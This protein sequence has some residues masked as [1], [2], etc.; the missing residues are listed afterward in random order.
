MSSFISDAK[1]STWQ[2]RQICFDLSRN[3][4]QLRKG[5][6]LIDSIN[7]VE[8]T[9]GNNGERGSLEITNLRILWASHKSRAN[10]SIGF[11]CVSSLRI[12][13]A[14]SKLRGHTQALF[15]MT[16]YGTSTFE[17]IF[18][19]LVKASPRLFTTIQAVFRSYETS[20]LYRDL[21]LRG[22]IIREKELVLLPQE[23]I[24]TRVS[25]VWNLSSD[26]GNL[27][28]LLITNVRIVWH[29]TLAENFNVS[30]PFIQLH[31]ACIRKSKFG[32]ALVL[33]TSAG[34][35]GYVLGFQIEPSEKLE[36]VFQELE[37]LHSI[38]YKSPIFGVEFDL[39]EAAP[40]EGIKQPRI[41]DDCEIE[42]TISGS[43][44]VLAAYHTT[45]KAHENRPISCS[46]EL[47]LAMECIPNGFTLLD[48]WHVA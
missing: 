47:G 2:D 36:S 8:D 41:M 43:M 34:S 7:S 6:V 17:F 13:N 24:Y 35:G 22:G 46:M 5:E 38:F 19:S 31:S 15:V 32:L 3:G 39:E 10:L 44:D 27:G 33:E 9:K 42:Q 40:L 29:A 20:K 23:E 12:R 26:Q 1:F 18:T 16:K 4:L 11:Q 30:I 48:L 25:G 21:K 14:S 45:L 37:R 28:S